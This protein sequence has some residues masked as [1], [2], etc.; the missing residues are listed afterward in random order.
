MPHRSIVASSARLMREFGGQVAI[1][2]AA[3]AVAAAFLAAPEMLLL[4]ERTTDAKVV[5]QAQENWISPIAPDG[6]IAIRHRQAAPATEVPATSALLM[7]ASLVMPMNTAWPQAVFEEAPVPAA[8]VR[9]AEAHPVAAVATPARKVPAAV[10]RPKATEAAPLPIIPARL[11]AQ[12][13][14]GATAVDAPAQSSA[15][16]AAPSTLA[17]VGNAMSGAVGTVGAAG[18]W[19]LSQASSLLPRL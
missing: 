8:R 5:R 12:L 13:G 2:V 11:T 10:E 4:P 7:R 14:G 9:S 6:K 15:G 18:I 3:S 1:S 16:E 17:R 19:T